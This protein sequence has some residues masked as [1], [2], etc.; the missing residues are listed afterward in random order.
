MHAREWV[1]PATCLYII[2]QLVK[3]SDTDPEIQEM[4]QTFDW[5]IFPVMNPDGYKYTWSYVSNYIFILVLK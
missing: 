1:A 5:Y 4:V 2:E 3:G